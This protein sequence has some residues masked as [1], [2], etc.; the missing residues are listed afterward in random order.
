M[1]E[2]GYRE[3][4]HTADWELEVWAPGFPG[5]LKQAAEG[6]YALAQTTL[7]TS[8]RT[9]RTITINAPDAEFRLLQAVIDQL[10]IGH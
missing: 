3:H 7:E 8:P 5:L 1:K 4:E 10:D 2:A 6:M 9:S